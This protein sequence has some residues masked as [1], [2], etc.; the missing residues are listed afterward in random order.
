M[1]RLLDSLKILNYFRSI[2][3]V[4]KIHATTLNPDFGIAFP[5][6]FLLLDTSNDHDLNT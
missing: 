6:N 4:C 2:Y 5:I 1:Y 3:F